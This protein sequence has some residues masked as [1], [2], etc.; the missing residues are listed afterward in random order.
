MSRVLAFATAVVGVS[1]ALFA[2]PAGAQ[3]PKTRCTFESVGPARTDSLIG[4]GQVSFAS[5]GVTVLCPSR[6]IKLTGDSAEQFPD[7]YQMIGHAVY[8]EPRFHVT[9]DYLNY[10]P[11]D[12]KVVG[13]GRV[14]ARLP[15]GSTLDGPQAEYRRAV[16]KIRPRA[17]MSAIARPT[18]TIIQK[19]SAGRP[20][21]ST[22]VTA[23]NV[24]VDGDSASLIYGGG[25]VV[26]N[27][28]D[29]NATADSAFINE[30]K[31]TM[32]LMR[33][34]MVKGKKD[35][36]FTLSGDLIDLFSR[37]RHLYRVLSQANAKA[38]SDSM[39]LA[40][41]TIDLR[42]RNDLLDHAYAWGGKNRAQ[43]VSPSQNL[44]ADSLDVT[45]PGQRI[46]LVRALR[47]AYATSKA[48]T[49]KFH[50]EK[51]DSTDWL[52]GDT[53]VAHF[54]S[55]R[56]PK[57]TSRNPA[58]KQLVAS[59][60]ASSYYHLAASDSSLKLPAIN[61]V[62]ARIITVNFDTLHKLARVTTV[63]SVSGIYIEPVPDST[64]KKGR[65]NTAPANKTPT[66]AKPSVPSVVP[67]PTKPPLHP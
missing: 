32:R 7:H 4:I 10:F 59:G 51:G 9:A 61:H 8:D 19:D 1:L 52:V 28:T 60:N 40:S 66:P 56:T 46:Q 26:I 29:I 62:N 14:H 20:P 6:G 63:D 21:D 31:E 50:V 67:V 44:L 13:A 41:D 34:P 16:P 27:R 37:D 2:A 55:T 30:P 5:G 47:R 49:T 23:N 11:N 53:I 45:M 39:T 15:S 65:G 25:Q 48:D 36:P 57:D 35:R 33:N 18:I 12:E 17:Q 22:K 3:T 64:Q 58:I 24:F 43:V 38:I 42:V 54:D